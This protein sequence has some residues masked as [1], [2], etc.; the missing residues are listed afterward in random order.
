MGMPVM[1]ECSPSHMGMRR[2]GRSR[3]LASHRNEWPQLAQVLCLVR[4]RCCLI[5]PVLLLSW[6]LV[7]AIYTPFPAMLLRRLRL[8]TH[9]GGVTSCLNVGL[10][11]SSYKKLALKSG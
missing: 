3:M 8:S 2:F 4:S 6:P 11:F 5:R 7:I 10:Y 1:G 9:S